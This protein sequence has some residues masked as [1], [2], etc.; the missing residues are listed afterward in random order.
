MHEYLF[1]LYIK[2]KKNTHDNKVIIMSIFMW[3]VI[4]FIIV[5]HFYYIVKKAKFQYKELYLLY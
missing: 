3:Y 1:I 2:Y 4:L 5:R